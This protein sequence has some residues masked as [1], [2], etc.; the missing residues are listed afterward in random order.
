VKTKSKQN[1]LIAY[2]LLGLFLDHKDVMFLENCQWAY[3]TTQRYN[4]D[5][6]AS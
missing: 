3:K 2:S 6:Y 1:L 5:D 4:P